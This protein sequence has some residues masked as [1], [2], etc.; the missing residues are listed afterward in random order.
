[1]RQRFR[2]SFRNTAG[3]LE[4][5]RSPS[6]ATRPWACS[7]CPISS[8]SRC[9]CRWSRPSS[10]SCSW[11]ASSTTS[12]TATTTLKPPPPPA[13]KSC[14]AYFLAF[15]LIDFITSSVA[16]IARTPPSRQQGRRLAA[17]PHLAAALRLPPGLLHRPLQD[18]QARHRRQ[19][20]QLG[21]D[22]AHRQDEQSHRRHYGNAVGTHPSAPSGSPLS[23][24]F[25]C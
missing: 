2:W 5:S 19:A 21:Q 6:S 14:V 15:L 18:S 13:S 7:R 17:L 25:F 24:A 11:P 9:C 10:T 23:T 8:S 22:R 20:L 1:M 12:S 3:R 4:T 16:F